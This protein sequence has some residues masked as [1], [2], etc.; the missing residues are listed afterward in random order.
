MS[1]AFIEPNIDF[2]MADAEL[3]WEDWLQERVND[4]ASSYLERGERILMC[5][6]RRHAQR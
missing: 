2:S 5:I 3:S 1:C 6:P 4:A